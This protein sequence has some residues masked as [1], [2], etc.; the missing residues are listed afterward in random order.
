VYTDH[1]YNYILQL[2]DN[3]Y[4]IID[5]VCSEKKTPTEIGTKIIYNTKRNQDKIKNL[6]YR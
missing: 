3:T 6:S 4:D 2:S 1:Y 5:G